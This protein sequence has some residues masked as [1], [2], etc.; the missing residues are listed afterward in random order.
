MSPAF[1]DCAEENYV[2]AGEINKSGKKNNNSNNG[3]NE[4]FI[5]EQ[6]LTNREQKG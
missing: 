3:I 1:K 4:K 6:K 2:F 5:F